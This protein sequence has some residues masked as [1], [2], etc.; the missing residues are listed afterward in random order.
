MGI[1]NPGETAAAAA[2]AVAP[3]REQHVV[4]VARLEIFVCRSSRP[5]RI[6]TALGNNEM[7]A[8]AVDLPRDGDLSSG[9]LC[10]ARFFS[11]MVSAF[12]TAIRSHPGSPTALASCVE[13]SFRPP[14]SKT[15]KAG[16][17]M[18]GLYDNSPIVS[19]L[20]AD[21]SRFGLILT[22][23]CFQV[24]APPEIIGLPTRRRP[25]LRIET[26]A[27][28]IQSGL[29]SEKWASKKKVLSDSARCVINGGTVASKVHLLLMFL[30]FDFCTRQHI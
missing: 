20:P 11:T 21:S 4:W 6:H 14:A 29:K 3:T 5:V 26:R 15:V 30:I 25:V 23:D 19:T 10:Q 2:A 18:A 17:R 16:P 8:S 22:F 28:F 13:S 7:A 12:T 27:I 24:R 1:L 9:L